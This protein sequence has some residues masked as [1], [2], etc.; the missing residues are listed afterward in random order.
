[1]DNEEL[2]Q[3]QR[4][5][6]VSAVFVVTGLFIGTLLTVQFNSSI[7]SAT[8]V[9]DEIRA[10]E[11][12]IDS[13]VSDQA[14]LKSKIVGLRRE[15]AQAQEEAQESIQTANLDT[16][17]RLKDEVGLTSIRGAG[18]EVFLDDGIFVN[19][20]NPDTVGQSLIHASDLRD[21]VNLLQSTNAQALSINGQRVIATTSI[22]SVGNTILVNNFHLLPPFTISAVGD[23]ETIMQR[24]NDPTAL[25]DLHKRAQDLNIQFSAETKDGVLV[26]EYSGNLSS[27]YISELEVSE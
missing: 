12:L 16:L 23:G 14:L 22:T 9:S 10:Q 26:S 3:W 24:L 1:M 21:V 18:V 7:P 27:A 11:E 5:W 15:I 25:P 17:K 6:K 8:F 2:Q 19:R 13:Y 20:E 4:S